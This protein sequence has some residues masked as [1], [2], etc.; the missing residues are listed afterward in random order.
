[1]VTHPSKIPYAVIQIF[2]KKIMGHEIPTMYD[3]AMYDTVMIIYRRETGKEPY[4]IEDD[5]GQRSGRVLLT[6]D[7]LDW[8]YKHMEF[9]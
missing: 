5:V 8:L 4:T 2:K 7:F 1:V 9:K 6:Q 3:T